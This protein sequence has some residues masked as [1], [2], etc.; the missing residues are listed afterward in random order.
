MLKSVGTIG[1]LLAFWAANAPGQDVS[2]PRLWA[3]VGAEQIVTE[4]ASGGANSLQLHAR[5]ASL[6]NDGKLYLTLGALSG[7]TTYSPFQCHMAR[8]I[9]CFG[10]SERLKAFE[11]G[12]RFETRPLFHFGGFDF[13][14][15]A[16]LTA[17]RTSLDMHETE[18]PTTLCFTST[19]EI[20]SCAD[21]PPF[22]SFED[23]V[24][25]V[26]PALLYGFVASRRFGPFS[27]QLEVASQRIGF[28]EGGNGRLKVVLSVGY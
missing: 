11:A 8:Q 25:R 26:R 4:H 22:S 1:C 9:Y 10:G 24:S 14:S 28:G 20:I 17:S 16:A 23:N 6:P 12:L 5:I 13:S 21:N 15:A 19:R 27:S 7:S 2:S 3:G 18:G